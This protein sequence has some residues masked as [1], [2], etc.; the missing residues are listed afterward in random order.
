[1]IEKKKS[2]R[3]NKCMHTSGAAEM[4]GLHALVGLQRWE[5]CVH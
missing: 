5:D 1:M 3:S 4:G 2:I